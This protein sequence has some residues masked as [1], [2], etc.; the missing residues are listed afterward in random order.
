LGIEEKYESY[1]I[2]GNSAGTSPAG[3]YGQQKKVINPLIP[4][5]PHPL[6]PKSRLPYVDSK[7]L[8][9]RMGL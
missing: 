2:R 3:I 1:S 5:S 8:A 7:V 9:A 4:S 6:I